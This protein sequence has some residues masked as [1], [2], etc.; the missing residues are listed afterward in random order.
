MV[1]AIWQMPPPVAGVTSPSWKMGASRK[2]RPSMRGPMVLSVENSS[3]GMTTCLLMAWMAS[4]RLW[5]RSTLEAL[6]GVL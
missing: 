5:V 2:P 4:P 6:Y 3:P 1:V